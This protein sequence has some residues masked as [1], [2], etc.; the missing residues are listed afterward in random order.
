MY[1]YRKIKAMKKLYTLFILPVLFGIVP[2]MHA[3]ELPLPKGLAETEKELVAGFTF[4]NNRR[5]P[6][7]AQPVRT[8]AE[9][10][11]MEYLVVTW[12]PAFRNIL[13]QIVA[14]GVTECKVI[15]T[16]GDEAGVSAFLEENGISLDNIT[17]MDAGAD[18]IWIRDYAGNTVYT[19]G[20]GDRAL[21]DWIYNRPRPQD[22]TMPSEHAAL[23]G[24]T[25]YVTDSGA[26]DL[27]NT[28]GN[29]M[30]D[31]LGTAFA[32]EL[33][34][35]E[36][37]AGNP[38]GVSAKTEEEIDE[39]MKD[40]MGIDNYIKMP[41]LPFDAI[42]HID[43]HMKLLDEETLLVSRYPDGVADGPQI[44]ENIEY[45]LDN[46]M[47]P[48]GTPYRVKWIDAPP[49]PGGDYP[50]TGGWYRTYSNAL[51]LNKSVLVPV[52][53]P[54]T[55][56]PALAFYRELMPGY[57]VVGI[58]VDNGDEPLISL[59]GAIHCIT[60][61]IGVNDPLLIVH[62]PVREAVAGSSVLIRAAISHSSG[63]GSAVVFWREKGEAAFSGLPMALSDADG[64]WAAELPTGFD[65]TD[66]EYYISATALSGK[67]LSRPLVAPEGFWT[68]VTET[69]SAAEWAANNI[70]G[71]YPNPAGESVSFSFK[72]IPGAMTAT[73]TNVLGQ[74]LY[75][76][77]VPNGNGVVTLQLDAEWKGTLFI[78]FSGDFGQVTKKVIRL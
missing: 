52:Y 28:G 57:N 31:G 2:Q 39:I 60:H 36:N 77:T 55:D 56:T 1:I 44:E 14:V 32:S 41:V 8:A 35:D 16:T 7:P 61:S 5:T 24:T 76:N 71:P 4:R 21:V 65:G 15:I 27:V 49:G 70:A 40:Y 13:R 48:F 20:V 58:D 46:F 43:M 75:H 64:A 45:V 42:H 3:Q 19:N 26:N 68:I 10:E 73:I 74:E 67:T 59:S 78:T 33:V 63:I 69:L 9:W 51:I 50:D 6:P 38:F 25:L 22:N 37:Q 54:E 12:D 53:R 18:S 11:E 34:L 30:S 17:F 23:T 29:F 62:Q 72:N 66:I 47:S